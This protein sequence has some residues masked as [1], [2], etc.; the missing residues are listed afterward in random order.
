MHLV[1]L[2]LAAAAAAQ[3]PQPPQPPLQTARQ[4][5]VME[6][7][8]AE[9][10]AASAQ[11]TQDLLA[12]LATAAFRDRLAA[13]APSLAGLA[14]ADLLDALRADLA[15]SE[16]AHGFPAN[17]NPT[18]TNALD[19]DLD[20]IS[21]A[22]WF[23]NQWQL[24]V[25]YEKREMAAY[26]E[27]ISFIAPAAAAE[28]GL[29]NMDAFSAPNPFGNIW[30]GGWPANLSEASDRV[31]YAVMNQD[32]VDYPCFLWGDV[33]V[34]FNNSY[35]RPM[36][37]LT[38][39][40]TGDFTSY[41]NQTFVDGFCPTWTNASA[42]GEFWFCGWDAASSS[43]VSGTAGLSRHDCT[44]WPNHP[45]G[46]LDSF[47]HLYVP[48]AN[49]YGE[50]AAADRLAFLIARSLLPWSETINMTV[51]YFDYY[52]EA[53]LAG[54]PAFPDAVRFV[55]ASIPDLFG[56]DLGTRVRAL[57]AK[58]GWP[59]V[60][61]LG[62]KAYPIPDPADTPYPDTWPATT[63]V[64]DP[65]SLRSTT[66][67]RNMTFAPDSADTM[68]RLWSAAVEFRATHPSPAPGD[69]RAWWAQMEAAL[70]HTLFLQPLRGRSCGTPDRCIGTTRD[71]DDCV[72]YQ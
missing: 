6:Q 49:W 35:L 60:W 28:M 11:G 44:V 66:V 68:G 55:I 3:P 2:L 15:V 8:R 37:I 50:G 48:F 21:N 7:V 23:Y 16:I 29:W 69:Y 45:M 67:A 39:M 53:D 18:Q 40:D 46:T 52:F 36:V 51:P 64:L 9:A 71:G 27:L 30:P 22:S 72:C 62:T 24:P 5:R 25:L 43:C 1:Y 10:Q 47:D 17:N 56:T 19:L 58:W 34:V 4:L 70:D 20:I 13:L 38:P 65:L 33:A 26:Y 32:K 12:F 41:C 42:C 61:S 59:L 14:P 57:C 31:V 63:R 54:N